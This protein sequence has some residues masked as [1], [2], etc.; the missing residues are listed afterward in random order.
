MDIYVSTC[1]CMCLHVNVGANRGQQMVSDTDSSEPPNWGTG[2][3]THA[4]CKSNTHS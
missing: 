4:L 2:N 3:Q 1:V